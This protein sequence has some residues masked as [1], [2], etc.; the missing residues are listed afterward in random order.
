MISLSNSLGACPRID[1]LTEN[2]GSKEKIEFLHQQACHYVQGYYYSK[3]LPEE[4]FIAY[5]KNMLQILSEPH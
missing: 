4:D 5:N 3:P 2:S 1:V